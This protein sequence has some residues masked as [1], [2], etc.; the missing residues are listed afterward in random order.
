MT[1]AILEKLHHREK[2]VF[3]SLLTALFLLAG[4]YMYFIN[5]TVYNV[6]A[7][8]NFDTEATALTVSTGNEEFQYIAMQNAITLPLAYSLGFT[9][10]V[11]K[12]FISENA[13][14]QVSF[15]SQ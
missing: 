13:L 6:I 12:T 4:M 10:V 14:N 1:Q 7:R 5:A 8:E 2:I 11:S 9:D 15:V 3:W